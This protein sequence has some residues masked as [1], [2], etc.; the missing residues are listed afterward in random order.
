V[1]RGRWPQAPDDVRFFAKVEQRGECWIW[2]ANKTQ[3]GY[4]Q[5]KAG[6]RT[7]GD[8]TQWAAHRWAY[9]HLRAE[10][11]EGL[12]L[13]HLCRNR[14]CVNPWHLEPVTRRVNTLRGETVCAANAAKT[15]CPRGHPYDMTTRQGRRG[16]REC[17]NAGFRAMR[18]RRK[19]AKS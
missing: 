9:T 6:S 17:V 2:I 13:D 12:D 5:F 1:S 8:R 11:P 3:W 16:C 15:H 10:I 7:T 18:A 4:G 19:A 14:A